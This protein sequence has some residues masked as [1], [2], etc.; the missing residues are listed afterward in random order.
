MHKDTICSDPKV[1]A[2][3]QARAAREKLSAGWILSASDRIAERVLAMPEAQ[4]ANTI[5]CY[6]ATHHE[7]QTGRIIKRL[8]ADGKRVCVP[9]W[10]RATA[11]YAMCEYAAGEAVHSGHMGV[12]EPMQP[13][14][15]Q[16]YVDVMVVPVLAFDRFLQRLGHGGG[17][18]DRLLSSHTGP[19]IGLAFEVQRLAAVPCERHDVALN[20]VATEQRIYD[21]TNEWAEVINAPAEMVHGTG[22]KR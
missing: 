7:V 20:F 8:L 13:R 21:G 5:G 19:K 3:E 12:Q 18:F 6:L 2:R 22:S 10:N 15:A 9:A 4:R 14:W 16:A 1:A 11:G 17:H